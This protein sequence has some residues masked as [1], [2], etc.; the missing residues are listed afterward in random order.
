LIKEGEIG[1][2]A[3]L[4]K[5]GEC[6]IQSQKNPLTAFE[7]PHIK[8]DTTLKTKRGFLSQSTSSLRFGI[9]ESNQWAGEERLL[10][11]EEQPFGYSIIARTPV[12]AYEI[13]RQDAKRK[14]PTELMLFLLKWLNSGSAGLSNAQNI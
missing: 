6:I 5:E 11:K 10:K 4:L 12:K 8:V 1:D 14:L 2:K 7:P 9:L 13:T 3:Y